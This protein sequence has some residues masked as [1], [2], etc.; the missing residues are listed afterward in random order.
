MTDEEE[1]KRQSLLLQSLEGNEAFRL[2]RTEICDRVI[3]QVEYLLAGSDTLS[4]PVLR[5][6]VKLKYLLKDAFYGVFERIRATNEND[7]ELEKSEQQ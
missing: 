1:L 4:E 6:N 7:K 3:E 5:A 2:W